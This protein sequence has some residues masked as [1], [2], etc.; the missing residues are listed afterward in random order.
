[1]DAAP[2]ADEHAVSVPLASAEGMRLNVRVPEAKPARVAEKPYPEPF[3]EMAMGDAAT[4]AALLRASHD[5]DPEVRRSAVWALGRMDGGV[6]IGSLVRS[7]NDTD[8]RVR[9]AAAMALGEYAERR[10]TTRI[11]RRPG[12]DS[13]RVPTGSAP[14]A[15]PPPRAARTDIGGG[16]GVSVDPGLSILRGLMEEDTTSTPGGHGR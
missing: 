13:S 6:V 15:G 1:V 8:A 10:E 9:S 4:L 11:A 2:P 14:A 7:M 16:G 5:A 3:P 12:T